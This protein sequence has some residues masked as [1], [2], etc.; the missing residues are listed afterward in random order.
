MINIV[1]ILLYLLLLATQ[2]RYG[3]VKPWQIRK[4]GEW[5][6]CINNIQVNFHQ[7]KTF[8]CVSFHLKNIF[9]RFLLFL[10]L[11]FII[12]LL[13][14][15]FPAKKVDVIAAANFTDI[16][17]PNSMVF[18]WFFAL[19]CC[20]WCCCPLNYVHSGTV[21]CLMNEYYSHF[22]IRKSIFCS[23]N[24]FSWMEKKTKKCHHKMAD[25][26]ICEESPSEWEIVN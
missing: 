15:N 3:N 26:T 23:R 22:N 10:F 7:L 19:F 20:C 11:D 1:G 12:S 13:F 17:K 16:V 9:L 4:M 2:T 21:D 5:M 18:V 14:C 6:N 24:N 25:A 8:F